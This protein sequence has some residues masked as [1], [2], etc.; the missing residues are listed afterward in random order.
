[1]D[2]LQKRKTGPDGEE[3]GVHNMH[4]ADGDPRAIMQKPL[5]LSAKLAVESK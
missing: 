2:V 5:A 1:M 3:L 4:G